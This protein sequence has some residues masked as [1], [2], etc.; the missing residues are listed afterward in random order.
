L[1]LPPQAATQNIVLW[2]LTQNLHAATP[3]L[4]NDYDQTALLTDAV[5]RWWLARKMGLL[6]KKRNSVLNHAVD[7]AARWFAIHGG[8]LDLVAAATDDEEAPSTQI[9]FCYAGPR[10]PR[11][12]S[13]MG[14]GRGPHHKSALPRRSNVSHQDEELTQGEA[15][16][17]ALVEKAAGDEW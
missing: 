15:E 3:D 12:K 5:D 8:K 1:P 11:L 6:H 13:S 17:F 2:I 14:R 16:Y 4:R 10:V 7:Q 9:T